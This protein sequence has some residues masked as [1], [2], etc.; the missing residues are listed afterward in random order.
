MFWYFLYELLYIILLITHR[1][2]VIIICIVSSLF[3]DCDCVHELAWNFKL[4]DTRFEIK[5]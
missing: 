4:N 5:V 2:C 1:I 3:R